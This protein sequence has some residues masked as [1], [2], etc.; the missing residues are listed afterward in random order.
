MKKNKVLIGP[1]SFAETDKTPLEMLA[2]AG[3]RAVDN[4]FRRKLTKSEILD[5]LTEDV[6]GI[7]AGLETLDREVLSHSRLRVVSRVGSG[8]ANVDLEAA[9]E[10]GIQVFSTPNGPV[11]AVAELT[12][13]S[14]LCLLRMIPQMNSALHNG[15]WE[16]R[17]GLQLEGKTVVIIGFG[18]IGRRVAGLLAAFGA[19]IVVVD[20]LAQQGDGS[21]FQQMTLAEAL[22]I[23]DIVTIHSSGEKCLMAEPEF[24]LLK[25]GAFLLNAARGGLVSEECLVRSL[26]NGAVAGAWVDAY[27]VEPY[28]GPLCKMPNVLLTPHAGSYTKECRKGMECDA[29]DNLVR[30]LA[31]MD[32]EAF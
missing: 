21:G 25:R 28:A 3:I 4:P 9:K 27:S 19:R 20:P 16:K 6:V 15:S 22:P 31:C 1:S 17:I 7:V 5:L 10:L 29:V 30:A 13:G 24:S 32:S 2:R 26:E 12:V 11:E 18:R 14:L 8:L 23:A